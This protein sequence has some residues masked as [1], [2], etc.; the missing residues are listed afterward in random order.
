MN[1][2]QKKNLIKII[3][4]AILFAVAWLL[5]LNGAYRFLVFFIPY[6][7]VGADVLRS[8]FRNIIN[9]QLLDEQFLMAAATLGAFV[10]KEY[11]EAVTVM[12]LYQIGEL[13][14]SIAV[15]KSR[16]SIAA[17][18]DIRPD[19]AAVI[20]CGKEFTVA[21][22]EVEVGEIIVVR[23]GEKIPLDGIITEGQASIDTA[24][25]TGES[26][27]RDRAEGEKVISGSVN[28]NGLI[29]IEVTSPFEQSTVSK[30]L[31][32]IEN[33]SAKKARMERFITR[34]AHF[35][36]NF[37]VVSAL[38]LALIP[39]ILFS[40][41]W[42]EA[43]NRALV[44]LVVSCPCALVISVPLSFFGGIGGASR[45]GILIKDANYIETL[46]KVKTVVFDKTGTLTKGSFFVTEISPNNVTERE[47]LA[48][49]A[50]AECYSNHPIAE[51][52][53]KAYGEDIDS[54]RI[55]EIQEM[56]GRGIKAVVDGR[57]VFAGNE[58]LMNEIGVDWQKSGKVGT[59]VHVAADGKYLGHIVIADEIKTGAKEA[60]S[61]LKD[62]G[63][64]KTVMLTG[65]IKAV[66]EAVARELGIN[67]VYTDIL[68]EGKVKTLEALLS[69]KAPVA[70]VGDGIND[71][72]VISR[73]DVGIAMGALGSDAAIEAADIVLMD[74]N[75]MKI[76]YAIK[77]SRRTMR[78]VWQNIIF[79][80]T[81]K[82]LVL[83]LGALGFAGMWIAVFADVGVMVIAVLNAMRTLTRRV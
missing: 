17:L 69:P 73:A 11:P 47:L 32:L 59:T 82:A 9:R 46:A 60:V 24:A 15:G 61:A 83:I 7:V 40:W 13:F 62:V 78:I 14:Q 42:S 10:I 4:A 50:A 36:T 53:L 30:I 31:E 25:L 19:F 55:G 21:P 16:R 64:T 43:L 58:R 38:L 54:S 12:I 75:I 81:T 63:I 23:P 80:L 77:F 41:E 44:F 35:Y 51:S 72:P 8:A 52:I 22:E 71:A 6:I 37:I 68:P 57:T 79:A 66:G 34:F 3:A 76:A 65:D 29:K 18:M 2:K 20:R 45:Q 33:S 70:F 5:P 56:P 49:T 28:L 1:K 48:I 27:P 39:P 26:M 67:E 74:D